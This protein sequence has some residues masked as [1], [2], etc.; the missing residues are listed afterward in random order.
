MT[1]RCLADALLA[2]SLGMNGMGMR[3][4][5]DDGAPAVFRGP[6]T[7]QAFGDQGD[8]EWV[9]VL[10]ADAETVHVYGGYGTARDLM[11]DGPADPLAYLEAIRDEYKASVAERS[12]PASPPSARRA[13][14][15]TPIPNLR[16]NA[17]HRG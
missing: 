9:Y 5:D 8:L 15:S 1:A 6:P 2:A 4:D 3:P 13:G 11:Q 17:P 10:D 14:R 7:A 12:G 16:E